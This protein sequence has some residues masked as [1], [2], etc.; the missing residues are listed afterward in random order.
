MI[1]IFNKVDITKCAVLTEKEWA[2]VILTETNIA[3][4][5]EMGMK[6]FHQ[7]REMGLKDRTIFNTDAQDLNCQVWSKLGEFAIY[8]YFGE[9]ARVTNPGEFHDYPD[10]GQ[11][12][13]RHMM[14]PTDGFII[15]VKD[16]DEVPM[17]LT[18]TKDKTFNDKTIWLIGWGITAQMRRNQYMFNQFREN[19]TWGTMGRDFEAHEQFIYPRSMLNPIYML[20]KEFVNT[21]YVKKVK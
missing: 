17:I 21:P 8:Q 16:Q 12:N 3:L 13:A 11:V 4:A 10:V 20:S 9:Q 14:D 5:K 19:P 18:T 7:S 1:K 2:P 6:Q 15:Q